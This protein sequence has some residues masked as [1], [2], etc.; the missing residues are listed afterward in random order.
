[1]DLSRHDLNVLEK[2]KD[3]ESAPSVPVLID[4][5]LARDPHIVDQKEYDR[6]A[7]SEREIIRQLQNLEA[8]K[9]TLESGQ[10][11]AAAQL[12]DGYDTPIS[13]LNHLITAYPTYASAHNNR[14][15]ALR[16][17]YG[18]AI[19]LSRPHTKSNVPEADQSEDGD[20]TN[21]ANSIL[22]DLDTAISLLTPRTPFAP[23]SSQ[24]AK[25][26]SQA[27]TQRATLYHITAKQMKDHPEARLRIM[28]EWSVEDLEEMASRDFTMGGRCG[29][30]IAKA[31]AVATNPTAKLCG[32]IV[33]EAMKKEY[34]DLV[35]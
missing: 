3:P 5:T 25:T 8:A 9:A 21:A 29:N 22:H 7:R 19:L 1:M 4:A 12:Q 11:T 13:E 17:K 20:V 14:A 23:I 18:D 26:L 2:I 15:Q 24:A 16:Q 34:G 28:R 31:L 10:R 33:Q 6:I 32:S 27:H 35:I 30:E